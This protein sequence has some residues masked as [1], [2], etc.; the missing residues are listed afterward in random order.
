MKHYILVISAFLVFFNNTK[1]LANASDSEPSLSEKIKSTHRYELDSKLW[2]FFENISFGDL[3]KNNRWRSSL[4]FQ[5]TVIDYYD[6]KGVIID[7][8]SLPFAWN[9]ASKDIKNLLPDNLPSAL[10]ADLNYN[11]N[12]GLIAQRILVIP[13]K[14]VFKKQAK[15]DWVL[16]THT[17]LLQTIESSPLILQKK[18]NQGSSKP[19]SSKSLLEEVDIA[20]ISSDGIKRDDWRHRTSDSLSQKWDQFL[21]TLQFNF[22]SIQYEHFFSRFLHIFKIPLR[23][24]LA[25]KLSMQ[26][27][28][29]YTVY[30]VHTLGPSF[31]YKGN[32]NLNITANPFYIIRNGQFKVQVLRTDPND[33]NK[34]LLK[35]SHLI[36]KGV[37]SGISLSNTSYLVNSVKNTLNLNGGNFLKK[38]LT[39]HITPLVYFSKNQT[40]LSI[41]E[42]TQTYVFDLSHPKAVKAYNYAALGMTHKTEEIIK[43][44]KYLGEKAPVKIKQHSQ[45]KGESNS[46]SSRFHI[47]GSTYQWKQD[48]AKQLNHTTIT[49]KKKN[50]HFLDVEGNISCDEKSDLSFLNFKKIREEKK[51]HYI[52]GGVLK[53]LDQ[54]KKEREIYITA[55][56]AYKF[57]VAKNSDN[58]AHYND[59]KKQIEYFNLISN[60]SIKLPCP[61]YKIQNK[62]FFNNK[63]NWN[64]PKLVKYNKKVSQ[65]IS[66]HLKNIKIQLKIFYDTKS[67]KHFYSYK[68]TFIVSAIQKA[69]KEYIN[70]AILSDIENSY[71]LSKKE[72]QEKIQ[73]YQ[74]SPKETYK[75]QYRFVVR[76]LNN[77]KNGAF[78]SALSGGLKVVAKSLEY[79]GLPY[80]KE[81]RLKAAMRQL[82]ISWKDIKALIKQQP[83]TETKKITKAFYNM[84]RFPHFSKEYIHFLSITSQYKNVNAIRIK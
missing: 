13:E 70:S 74:S 25:K 79:L 80:S 52:S 22:D 64:S 40:K 78:F 38:A 49:F 2:D 35:F 4:N 55:I 60:Q 76:A 81:L 63:Y 37:G 27:T 75:Q 43:S 50:K 61:E 24:R 7:T 77:S 6:N 83:E 53:D 54:P 21:Y 62:K 36:S 15:K 32:L 26:E 84:F 51:L 73:Q 47:L 20:P 31:N 14:E 67:I 39:Y 33:V 45:R 30:G 8:T 9:V 71:L 46:T 65:C 57:K 3:I 82:F 58:S 56:Y 69:F 42:R 5:R 19:V 28:I 66:K 1:S 68:N 23:A 44:L 16:E 34:V 12:F 17:Q 11:L 18:L 72:K 41:D 48:C 59:V 29:N 10:S